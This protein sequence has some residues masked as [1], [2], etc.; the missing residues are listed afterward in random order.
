MQTKIVSQE[1][2]EAWLA[3]PT[4]QAYRQWMVQ[5]REQIKEQWAEG[6]FPQALELEAKC[7]CQVLQD[8]S[9]MNHAIYEQFMRGESDVRST[10]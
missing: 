7:K 10:E 3:H 2:W 4:T 1:Q 5:W 6:Q 8:L 9:E